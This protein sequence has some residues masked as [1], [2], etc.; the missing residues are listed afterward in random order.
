MSNT[1]FE[2]DSVDSETNSL[3]TSTEYSQ[4]TSNQVFDNLKETTNANTEAENIS[5]QITEAGISQPFV[6]S[7]GY[8]EGGMSAITDKS[9]GTK[10]YV[11]ANINNEDKNCVLIYGD[12]GEYY[13]V[14][15]ETGQKYSG[16]EVSESQITKIYNTNAYKT[17]ADGYSELS[18]PSN[19]LTARLNGYGT[20]DRPDIH[21]NYMHH[22]H[23]TQRS[24]LSNLPLI[25]TGGSDNKTYSSFDAAVQQYMTQTGES[26]VIAKEEVQKAIDSGGI[27]ISDSG[28]YSYET[29]LTREDAIQKL[30]NSGQWLRQDAE[31]YVDTYAKQNNI[32]FK[33]D[34]KNDYF[35]G[36]KYQEWYEALKDVDCKSLATDLE[37]EVTSLKTQFENV[38]NQ[39]TEWEGSASGKAKE[40]IACI[41]GKFIV[42]MDNIENSLEPATVA[43]ENLFDTLEDLKI[44]NDVLKKYLLDLEYL[45]NN[46]P[47]QYETKTKDDGTTYKAITSSYKNWESRINELNHNI[48][49]QRKKLDDIVSQIAVRLLEPD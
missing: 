1:K 27:K 28:D 15:A 16:A 23:I 40:A 43:I 5:A 22:T 12:E 4:S 20:A 42:T 45:N 17:K 25:E 36:T 10:Y 6:E 32:T 49:T 34:L 30:T 13:L 39:L 18:D 24:D 44:E 3:G 48:E 41:L 26:E 11:V 7:N 2:F 19:S 9:N 38:K 14:D 35:N 33:A 8:V 31:I 46:Q 37:L 29:S 21:D 47:R